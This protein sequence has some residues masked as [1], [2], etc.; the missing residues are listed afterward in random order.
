MAQIEKL[1]LNC[2]SYEAARSSLSQLYQVDDELLEFVMEAI[3]LDRMFEQGDVDGHPDSVLSSLIEEEIGGSLIAPTE[4]H[5]FHLSRTFNV[6]DYSAGIL[7]LGEALDVVWNIFTK[8]FPGDPQS[9]RL[10]SMR[11]NGVP[12]FQY[13]HKVGKQ[14][15]HGPYAMLVKEVAFHSKEIGNHNYFRVPEIVEDICSGYMSKFGE[16]IYD[17]VVAQLTPC[18]VE[19]RSKPSETLGRHCAETA[20]YYVYNHIK[21]AK[22]SPYAN[23]CYDGKGVGVSPADI[24][25]VEFFP[26][27]QS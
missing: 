20:A 11:E 8:I 6:S 14:Y 3:D 25:R 18:S 5:W 27:Y 12:N 26:D 4:V 7:P 21:K 1:V 10:K 9:A 17:D 23:T 19:F 16:T 22:W 13:Q 15:L 24:L 2:A